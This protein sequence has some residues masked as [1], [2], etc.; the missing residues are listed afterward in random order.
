MF[1]RRRGI[2]P[3]LGFSF[4]DVMDH[5]RNPGKYKWLLLGVFSL[6]VVGIVLIL[7][8]LPSATNSTHPKEDAVWS[9]HFQTSGA[10]EEAYLEKDDYVIWCPNATDPGRVTV[11]DFSGTTI[12]TGKSG[13]SYKSEEGI[14]Y[15][16]IG[17]L[18]I[19][20]TGNYTIQV[21]E[22]G[23]LYITPY[24]ETSSG[25]VILGCCVFLFG[26][27]FLGVFIWKKEQERK[28]ALR[29]V[30]SELGLNY[31]EHDSYNIANRYRYLT[32]LKRGQGER[33]AFNVLQG[34]YRNYGVLIFD[35]H[36]ATYHHTK[37]G[38]KTSHHYFSAAILYLS[39]NFPEL[40]MEPEGLF[41]KLKQGLGWE[42]IDLDNITFSKEYMVKCQSKKFAYDIF[43]PRMMELVLHVG[44]LSMEIERDTMLIHFS[45]RLTPQFIQAQLDILAALRDLFPAYLFEEER[46]PLSPPQ[47]YPI[48]PGCGQ[49]LTWVEEYRRW[50]C[51]RCQQYA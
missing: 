28:Q 15:R 12:F 45:E 3:V 49:E 23:S 10:K 27:I 48:C 41:D 8:F 51:Y 9:G 43:T 2:G 33:Y 30:A 29:R 17:Q 25:G 19:P 5:F 26:I 50:Y 39:K 11:K 44:P 40:I 16:K 37:R 34:N 13:S 14:S 36:Y 22:E 7:F 32:P 38:T 4:S 47:Q 31:Q 18:E 24:Q 42:D 20:S 21:E 6:L 35:Y 1:R 46:T